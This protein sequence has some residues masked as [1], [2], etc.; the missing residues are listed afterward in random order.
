MASVYT[1]MGITAENAAAKFGITREQ[2][3]AFALNGQ[4]KASAASIPHT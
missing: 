4:K 2:Q 1:P 3:D